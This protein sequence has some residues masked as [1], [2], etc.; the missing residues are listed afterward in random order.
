MKTQKSKE[1]QVSSPLGRGVGEG[2]L[3]YIS[4]GKTP[5]EHLIYI[6][7]ACEAGCRWVQLR[8]K[9]VDMAT[10]LNTSLAC[11]D[12]CDQYGAIMI[13]NDSVSIAKAAMA[14]GVHLGLD[15][16]N[17]KEAREILGENAIIGGTANTL[18]D[19]IQHIKDGVDYIGVGPFRYTKTKE[20]LSPILGS[21]GY[22]KIIFALNRQHL[23]IPIIAIG[24]IELEDIKDI[25]ETGV[26]GI[27]VS[28]MLTDQE[29]LEEIIQKIKR[30]YN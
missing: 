19:C 5:K 9:N 18:E 8:L 21:E 17:P 28:G 3:Q 13:I 16:M 25:L 20:K 4:Q 12:I 27:A 30:V 1:N 10:Y 2:F 11:R 7:E 6:G 24:G 14:D 23:E 26:R 29:D 22:Q 15:D